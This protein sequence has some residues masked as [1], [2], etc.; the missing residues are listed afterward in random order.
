METLVVVGFCY[1]T[2][3]VTWCVCFKERDHSS[4]MIGMQGNTCAPV[5]S[6]KKTVVSALTTWEREVSVGDSF[7]FFFLFFFYNDCVIVLCLESGFFSIF[8]YILLGGSVQVGKQ[9]QVDVCV[10]MDER[11]VCHCQWKC[12]LLWVLLYF[13]LLLWRVVIIFIWHVNLKGKQKS[14]C[15]Y[16]V[17]LIRFL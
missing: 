7:S 10:G 1:Q 12:W 8:V 16:L 17:N 15:K 6:K 13:V 2:E 11:K 9:R 5:T 14:K 4:C 3:A